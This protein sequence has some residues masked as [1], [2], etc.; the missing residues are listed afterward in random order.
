MKL[1][2]HNYHE[3][4]CVAALLK[5]W[6]QLIATFMDSI[7]GLDWVVMLKGEE[8]VISRVQQIILKKSTRSLATL[9]SGV[10]ENHV[11][12]D[13]ASITYFMTEYPGLISHFP[14]KYTHRC[15]AL[16]RLQTLLYWQ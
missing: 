14:V 8:P 1:H 12:S 4:S 5:I 7:A 2:H 16:E 11:R 6:P 9:N 15:G 10:I 3:S 13:Y